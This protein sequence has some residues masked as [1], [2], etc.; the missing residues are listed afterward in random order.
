MVC[1]FWRHT[2]YTHFFFNLQNVYIVIYLKFNLVCFDSSLQTIE[3]FF[4]VFK[5]LANCFVFEIFYFEIILGSRE[6]VPSHV[7]I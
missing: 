4:N 3:A 7:V 2:F 1:L 5:S 6:V